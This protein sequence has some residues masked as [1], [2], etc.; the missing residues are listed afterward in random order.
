VRQHQRQAAHDERGS[1]RRALRWLGLALAVSLL[2]ATFG[3]DAA[4]AKKKKRRSLPPP[5]TDLPGQIDYYARQLA[6]VPLDESAPLTE[7]IQ[8]LVLDHL[9]EWFAQQPPSDVPTG[10]QVR[11]ELENVFSKLHYPFFGQ[12]AV[13]T[14][15]W[16][17]GT[18]IGA[19]Y[20]LGWTDYDRANVVALFESREGKTRQAALTNFVPRADLHYERLIVPGTD[21]FRFFVYGTR[22]GKSQPRLTVVLYSYDGQSLKTLWETRDVYDGKMDVDKEKVTIRYLKEEEYIRETLRKRKPPRY[23]AT[24]KITPQG[25][26]LEAEH[27]IQF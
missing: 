24:Y 21:D 19:G 5:P 22:L 15:P 26:E 6:G 7:K 3:L 23:E 16:K 4:G 12:P 14:E 13:F 11:R 18:L 17:G 27:E 25:L 9:G 20:T 10:V 2:T 8:K 1:R